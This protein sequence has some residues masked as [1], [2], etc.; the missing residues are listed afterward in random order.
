[1]M[2]SHDVY[3]RLIATGVQGITREDINITLESIGKLSIIDGSPAIK[4]PVQMLGV[5]TPGLEVQVINDMDPKD[6]IV[7]NDS[8]GKVIFKD[9]NG[10]RI[11]LTNTFIKEHPEIQ[12][13]ILEKTRTGIN[14]TF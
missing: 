11:E 9:Q 5:T 12:K 1:M 2:F 13:K 7:D 4:I 3:N 6:V 8:E 14:V 10:A